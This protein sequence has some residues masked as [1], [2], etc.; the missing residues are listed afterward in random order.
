MTYLLFFTVIAVARLINLDVS[1]HGEIGHVQDVV[2]IQ[3][4]NDERAVPDGIRNHDIITVAQNREIEA[5][6]HHLLG[7]LYK[8]SLSSIKL[9]RNFIN[10]FL[11]L[12]L[13]FCTIESF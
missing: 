3:E 12:F 8:S 6:G 2:H 13:K 9:I 7:K 5:Q 4:Q 1:V 10:L 11:F